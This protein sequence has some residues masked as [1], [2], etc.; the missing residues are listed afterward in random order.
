L[1]DFTRV[2]RKKHLSAR[3][4]WTRA[5]GEIGRRTRFRS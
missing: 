1:T 2:V 5:G 3:F 4:V